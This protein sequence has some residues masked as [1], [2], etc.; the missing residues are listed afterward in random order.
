MKNNTKWKF[1]PPK[2]IAEFDLLIK[3]GQDSDFEIIEDWVHTEKWT[4]RKEGLEWRESILSY[5]SEP[6]IM[7]LKMLSF[8]EVDE[9]LAAFVKIIR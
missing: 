2:A 7:Q 3:A 6:Q 9:R 4:F 8:Q 1:R 5:W